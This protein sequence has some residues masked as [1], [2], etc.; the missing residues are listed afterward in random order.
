MDCGDRGFGRGS[1][2]HCSK[3]WIE[4][5]WIGSKTAFGAGREEHGPIQLPQLRGLLVGI[6]FLDFAS[7]KSEKQSNRLRKKAIPDLCF[8]DQYFAK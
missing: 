7:T 8:E 3:V 4:E 1:E 2:R 6:A 5:A